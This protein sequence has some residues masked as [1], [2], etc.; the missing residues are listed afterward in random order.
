M[1]ADVSCPRCLRKLRVPEGFAGQSVRCPSCDTAF[2]ADV[3][4]VPELPAGPT[5]PLPSETFSPE[6]RPV[7]QPPPQRAA[8]DPDQA[9]AARRFVGGWPVV[10]SGLGWIM[11]DKSIELVALGLYL[12]ELG[13]RVSDFVSQGGGFRGGFFSPSYPW[14]QLGACLRSLALL[15]AGVFLLTGLA[16]CARYPA[17]GP[18]R[19]VVLTAI[20][21][22]SIS[23][24]FQVMCSLV[25][26]R[27]FP[28]SDLTGGG[29]WI[30]VV[31][32]M[33]RWVSEALLIGFLYLLGRDWQHEPTLARL[34]WVVGLLVADIILHLTEL[35]DLFEN[36]AL[37]Q[38][39]GFFDPFLVRVLASGAQVAVAAAMAAQ[40]LRVLHAARGALAGE[41]TRRDPERD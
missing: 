23:C 5:A 1:H 7:P 32:L 35:V 38:R 8:P 30:Y 17:P 28:Y 40:T 29:Y 15:A 13:Y 4:V 18:A 39:S 6:P 19:G 11:A 9:D 27:I 3:P 25:H 26:V 20:V 36:L 33:V 31:I 41:A 14:I 16:R 24:L 2:V 22:F 37:A 34:R 12:F 10:R 21:F